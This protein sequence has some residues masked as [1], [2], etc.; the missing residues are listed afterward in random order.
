[1]TYFGQTKRV[2]KSK[3]IAQ[4]KEN[5]FLLPDVTPPVINEII[6]LANTREYPDED[7]YW[8]GVK[9]EQLSYT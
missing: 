9:D 2:S 8:I 6:E 1:M 7:V 4:P 3:V 5:W